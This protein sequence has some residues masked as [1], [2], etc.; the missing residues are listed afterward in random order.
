MAFGSIFKSV[1]DAVDAAIVKFNLP[2]L[3]PP[4]ATAARVLV[5][6]NGNVILASNAVGL[7]SLPPG[8]L[9]SESFSDTLTAAGSNQGNALL[10]VSEINRLTTVAASTGV[11]LPPSSPGLTIYVIN[12]GA[13]PLQVYG[14]G[15]DTI[16]DIATATGV[17]QMQGSL[18]LYAC[19]TAGAWYSNGLGTGYA[20]SLET[21]SYTD[22]LTASGTN[23]QG[24]PPLVTT[25]MARFTTVG[26]TNSTTLMPAAP[27]LMVTVINA[28]ANALNVFPASGDAIN[29]LGANASFPAATTVKTYMFFS[30][31]AGHWHT[32]PL[33]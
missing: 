5:D 1:Y 31:V 17:T 19:T 27:G 24:S 26:A 18:V 12:H 32:N 23:A 2:K 6:I 29:A 20:G 3:A 28:G 30:T 13:N 9:I 14:S 8:A 7:T 4:I 22:G 25:A 11:L 21:Q 16:D 10:L 33:A 15:T